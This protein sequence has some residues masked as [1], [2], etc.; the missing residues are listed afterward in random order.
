MAWECLVRVRGAF[1]ANGK[2][3]ANI[4][5]FCGPNTTGEQVQN[6]PPPPPV[7]GTV[8]DIT[9]KLNTDL[10]AGNAVATAAADEAEDILNKGMPGAAVGNPAATPAV[11]DNTAAPPTTGTVVSTPLPQ[12]MPDGTTTPAG[13]A[14]KI[15]ADN[16]PAGGAITN[17]PPAA[18]TST[19]TPQDKPYTDPA[20]SGSFTSVPWATPNDFAARWNTFAGGVQGTGLFGLWG[21]A[22]GN[23]PTGGSSSYTFNAGVFGNH[24]YD[25]SS[26]GSTV[27]GCLSGLVQI[28]CAFVAI[29][30]ATLGKG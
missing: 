14:A 18:G 17:T 28:S 13:E 10:A 29:K 12:P 19:A 16:L 30:I 5:A 4:T 8:N 20:Y 22:F 11:T 23:V 3:L 9:S 25:F 1:D 21:N 24:T 7:A 27:F 2:R 15:V 26:W 6:A